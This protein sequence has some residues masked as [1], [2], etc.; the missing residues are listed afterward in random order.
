MSRLLINLGAAL[1]LLFPIHAAA[2]TVHTVA[3][4][5]S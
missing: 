2:S 1:F 4:H 5:L 3:L